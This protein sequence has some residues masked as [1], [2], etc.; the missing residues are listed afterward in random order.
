MRISPLWI[1]RF[2]EN[3]LLYNDI[4]EETFLVSPEVILVLREII[5]SNSIQKTRKKLS[6]KLNEKSLDRIIKFLKKNKFLSDR[7]F[8]VQKKRLFFKANPKSVYF[9]FIISLIIILLSLSNIFSLKL[10]S[11]DLFI[12]HSLFFVLTFYFAWFFLT[13]FHEL[14][15]LFVANAFGCYGK[16]YFKT[17]FI[18]PALITNV[19]EVIF[20]KRPKRFLVHLAGMF[21]D[22][23]MIA[24]FSDLIHFSPQYSNIFKFFIMIKAI[25]LVSQLNLYLRTDLY[26]V[27]EDFF[28]TINLKKDT[29]SFIKSLFKKKPATL[30]NKRWQIFLFLIILIFGYGFNLIFF[31]KFFIPGIQ[32]MSHLPERRLLKI[33]FI[34]LYLFF[35]LFHFFRRLITH[36][37][38]AVKK[39]S[40]N[41]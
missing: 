20:L 14:T 2:K 36:Q 7:S 18:F 8:G 40:K 29:L 16:I 9:F 31:I 24:I 6:K 37:H 32:Q 39:V 13:L 5:K 22:L 21:T 30:I 34:I 19:P 26:F 25:S 41:L 12:T 3:F 4:T 17:L 28:N 27:I 35:V 23:L 38:K 15:H 33:S 10:T 11:D 1:K